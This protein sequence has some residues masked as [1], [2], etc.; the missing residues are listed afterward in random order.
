MKDVW[1]SVLNGNKIH[2]SPLESTRKREFASVLSH[3]F[4]DL[5]FSISLL[6]DGCSKNT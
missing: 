5:P 6:T 1:K 2:L 3:A 4:R